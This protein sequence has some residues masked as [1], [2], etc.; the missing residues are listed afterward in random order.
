VTNHPRIQPGP[1]AFHDVRLADVAALAQSDNVLLREGLA[2]ILADYV[3][4]HTQI[5][6]TAGE[7]DSAQDWVVDV[8]RVLDCA[9]ARPDESNMTTVLAVCGDM[10]FAGAAEITVEHKSD[11]AVSCDIVRALRALGF[12]DR[13]L[14]LDLLVRAVPHM[15]TVAMVGFALDDLAL[16]LAWRTFDQSF[17]PGEARATV[18]PL[19]CVM[20]GALLAR[21]QGYRELDDDAYA[22]IMTSAGLVMSVARDLI[23][24]G[25]LS[26]EDWSD[27][28]LM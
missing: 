22:R 2:A 14:V 10:I 11:G 26:S 20:R 25:H 12:A 17:L 13:A 15:G 21:A 8:V 5:V 23:E 1:S 27:L 24:A 18:L 9:L 4:T 6:D 3:D 7:I 16:Y 28:A 19:L